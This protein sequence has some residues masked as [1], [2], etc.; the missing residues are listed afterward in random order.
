M[1]ETMAIGLVSFA[2]WLLNIPMGYWRSGARK[3]SLRWF[4]AVHLTVP[5]IFLL[6]VKAGLG[7]GYIPELVLFAVSGQLLGGKLNELA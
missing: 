4:L 6:R 3:F 7:Y 5:L 1:Y 2:A